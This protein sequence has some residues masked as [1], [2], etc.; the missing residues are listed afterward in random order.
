M[1]HRQTDYN[2]QEF[3]E[4]SDKRYAGGNLDEIKRHNVMDGAVYEVSFIKDVARKVLGVELSGQALD[5]GCGGGWVTNVLAQAGFD[6]T[7]MDLSEEGIALAKKQFPEQKFFVGNGAKPQDY[8]DKPAFDLIVAREFHPFTRVNDFDYQKDI[9]DGYLSLLNPKGVMVIGHG[10]PHHMS[11][12]ET[13]K[14]FEEL[15]FKKLKA[16]LNASGQYRVVGPYYYHLY[17]KL[18]M[19]PCTG[20]DLMLANFVTIAAAKAKNVELLRYLFIQKLG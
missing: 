18:G 13:G 11:D 6:A 17:K 7:G 20:I 14:P 9:V 16:V 10:R 12:P 19:M 4:R 8:F 1:K 5:T 3:R 2:W 15:D